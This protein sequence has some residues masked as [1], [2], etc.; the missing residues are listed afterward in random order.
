LTAEHL[1]QFSTLPIVRYEQLLGDPSPH[2]VVL[3]PANGWQWMDRAIA[4]DGL[5][6]KPVA[7]WFDGQV[8]VLGPA[9]P[10]RAP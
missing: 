1:A 3:F 10:R 7:P 9:D 8:A 6:V 2:L 4:E 5:V